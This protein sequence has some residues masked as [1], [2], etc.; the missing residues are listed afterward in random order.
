MMEVRLSLDKFRWYFEP[1]VRLRLGTTTAW[2]PIPDAKKYIE[3]TTVKNITLDT[4]ITNTMAKGVL[5]PAIRPGMDSYWVTFY[6]IVDHPNI[7]YFNGEKETQYRYEFPTHF[8]P[9]LASKIA[10]IMN[11]TDF[12]SRQDWKTVTPYMDPTVKGMEDIGW[13]VVLRTQTAVNIN[14]YQPVYLNV[15]VLIVTAQERDEWQS[16]LLHHDA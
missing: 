12:T 2:M 7:L 9:T 8:P 16:P 6:T 5:L 4:Q 11:Q 14:T 15:Y 13:P 1:R 10:V 3:T